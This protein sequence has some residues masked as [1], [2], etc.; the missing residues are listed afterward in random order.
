MAKKNPYYTIESLER[1]Q[2]REQYLSLTEQLRKDIGRLYQRR[3][4]IDYHIESVQREIM[5]AERELERLD[6]DLTVYSEPTVTKIVPMS[7]DE[8]EAML[9]YSL[10][11]EEV[12]REVPYLDHLEAFILCL[13]GMRPQRAQTLCK[14]ARECWYRCQDWPKEGAWIS[15]GTIVRF[16][17]CG[18]T[19][20]TACLD[21][22]IDNEYLIVVKNHIPTL[23]PRRFQWSK[24]K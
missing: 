3:N 22:L 23:R 9:T 8:W 12:E 15:W 24:N 10:P 20:A 16:C 19:Q 11:E 13:P 4:M 1:A 14:V 18:G 17:G 5:L 2:Q 21:W 6:Q 7:Q